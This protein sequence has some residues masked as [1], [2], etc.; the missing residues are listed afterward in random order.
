MTRKLRIAASLFTACGL[1]LAVAASA[2]QAERR[3]EIIT[4]TGDGPSGG[5]HVIPLP[6]ISEF[7][8]IMATPGGPDRTRVMRLALNRDVAMT[9]PAGHA[10]EIQ[11]MLDRPAGALSTPD[12]LLHHTAELDLDEAQVK[13]L[14]SLH[15]IMRKQEVRTSAGAQLAEIDVQA[16]ADD[17]AP[18]LAALEEAFLAVT[19]AQTVLHMLPFRLSREARDELNDGQL[20]KWDELLRQRRDADAMHKAHASMMP[21]GVGAAHGERRHNVEVEIHRSELHE[22]SHDE[23][24][25]GHHDEEDHH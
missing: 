17:P 12:M 16:L 1:T 20:A 4:L 14:S 23:G 5:Q 19:K 15:I 10:P 2:Q 9:G 6:Q 21:G 13:A 7:D 3:M 22:R 11:A 8:V 18:D 24:G 25:E